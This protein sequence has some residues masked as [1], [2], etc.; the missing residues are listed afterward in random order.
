MLLERGADPNLANKVTRHPSEGIYI[1]TYIHI[2]HIIHIHTYMHTYIHIPNYPA[3]AISQDGDTVL[4]A[5][6]RSGHRDAVNLLLRRGADPNL[7]NQV[8]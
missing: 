8:L 7:A 6:A 5:A 3:A 1:H 2:H 4:H